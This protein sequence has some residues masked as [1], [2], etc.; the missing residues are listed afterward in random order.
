M[1]T[2]KKHVIH[3]SDEDWAEVKTRAAASGQSVSAYLRSLLVIR[4]TRPDLDFDLPEKKK[5][6]PLRYRS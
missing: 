4:P 1:A 5:V 3:M 2:M 6:D